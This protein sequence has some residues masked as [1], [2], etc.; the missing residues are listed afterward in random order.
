M[1]KHWVRQQVRHKD[2]VQESVEK[3]V[4]WVDGNRSFAAAAAAG[5][6]VLALVLGLIV[7]HVRGA[8]TQSWDRLAV[9]QGMAYGGHPDEAMA[10]IKQLVEERPSSDA[11][12]FGRLF[13]GDVA[14]SRGQYKEA[15]E[16]YNSVLEKG[17]PAALQPIALSDLAIT[18]EA[19]GQLQ[20]AQ[21]TAQ[22]FLDQYPDHFLAPQVHATLAR[23]LASL[24]QTEQ[25]KTAYQKIALQYEGTTWAAW[26][27]LRL[28]PAK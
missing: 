28:Q 19:D 10:Q 9:A 15:L 12:A 21:Q 24:G 16:Q 1:G 11:A 3:S 23:A 13:A 4:N 2:L 7:S 26:A 6:A 17:T 14:F 8:A 22:K 25:A 27:A 20:P 18:Q 5:A